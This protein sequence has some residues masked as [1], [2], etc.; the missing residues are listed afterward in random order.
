MTKKTCEFCGKKFEGEKR[1]RFCSLA[2]SNRRNAQNA[3]ERPKPLCS[4]DPKH[5]LALARGWCQNCYARWWYRGG[6]PATKL[7]KR[8]K[9]PLD[10]RLRYRV[11]R[12]TGCWV[13][14]G[15]T[16]K[17]GYGSV[18]LDGRTVYIHRAW[19]EFN[20]GP[21]PEGLQLDHLCA[22]KLCINLEHL[23]PVTKSANLRR[24]SEPH[25]ELRGS[26]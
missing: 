6:D 25:F 4:V 15:S 21:V 14:T 17:D 19:W 9:I 22:N 23:E 3:H 2:C 8:V 5:G 10:K 7:P 16:R 26:A 1:R 24:G 13:W 11:D 18:R 12:K 20:N